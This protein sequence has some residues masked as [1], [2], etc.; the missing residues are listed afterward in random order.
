METSKPPTT[1]PRVRNGRDFDRLQ[2]YFIL[3]KKQFLFAE[4]RRL[5]AVNIKNWDIHRHTITHNNTKEKH[6]HDKY[7]WLAYIQHMVLT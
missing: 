6:E 5:A 3:Q 4:R 1:C 2:V 7:N